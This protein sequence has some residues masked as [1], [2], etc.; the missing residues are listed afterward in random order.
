[1]A[2]STVATGGTVCCSAV[3]GS[4]ASNRSTATA[5]V[6]ATRMRIRL[7]HVSISALALS[8]ANWEGDT[9]IKAAGLRRPDRCSAF[10]YAK[11]CLNGERRARLSL[12]RNTLPCKAIGTIRG[13]GSH[14]RL[15]R[16]AWWD[17]FRE[18]A[19]S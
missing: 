6:D 16:F 3:A 15:S 14:A 5:A 17:A 7:C 12:F 9:A 18:S 13:P 4:L 10:C 2:R 8:L 1:M 11:Y 19:L